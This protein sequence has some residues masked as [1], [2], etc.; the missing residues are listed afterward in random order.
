MG[1]VVVYN[2]MGEI[3][4]NFDELKDF[5]DHKMK[6]SHIYQPLLILI[7]LDSGGMATLRQ[8]AVE[9][10]GRDEAQIA[11]YRK[12]IR[13]MPVTVLKKH[14]VVERDGELVQLSTHNLKLKERAEL[15]LLC[16]K[17]IQEYIIKRD[18]S[19]WDYKL[20]DNR[21]IKDKLREL[22]LIEA[23]GRCALCGRTKNED[24]LEVDHIKPVSKGGKSTYENLQV[25]C[26]K[27]NGTK[28][29]RYTGDFR[30]LVCEKLDDCLFCDLQENDDK[31]K[32]LEND[33]AYAMLDK[34][35][36]TEGHTLIIPK[37]HIETYFE[38][39]EEENNAV[40][41]LVKIRRKQLKEEDSTISG[42]NVGINNGV[43]AGQT[44]MHCHIHLI[45]RRK[46]DVS[47]PE[48]G[49]RGVLPSKQKYPI[50]RNEN[51]TI[52]Y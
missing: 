51:K 39:T 25:L 16:E 14:G 15:K 32:V 42:F 46:G 27:C 47:E 21:N 52:E 4:M 23:G 18:I 43:S 41:E 34:H 20:L 11:D 5:I 12:R 50:D 38:M 49:V 30:E 9:F 28:S 36:V 17:K 8:L 2:N 6:M 3:T 26:K 29:N 31:N 48:G 13:E 45:P 24:Q 37:R 7:L 35:P 40:F 22:V 33:L 44:V 1:A 19:T 10:I